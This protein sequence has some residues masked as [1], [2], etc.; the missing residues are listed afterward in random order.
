MRT[1]YKYPLKVGHIMEIDLPKDA[2]PLCVKMQGGM[3]TMWA[4]VDS[5]RPK[6]KRIFMV[7]GTGFSL[8][9]PPLRYLDTMFDG[10]FVWHALEIIT[11]NTP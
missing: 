3:P 2:K 8:D 6:E 5:E 7:T 11:P 1:I 9:G 10:A 4:F